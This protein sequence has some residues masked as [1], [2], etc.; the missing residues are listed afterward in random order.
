MR[1]FKTAL[2]VA[3]LLTQ[4]SSFG[5]SN[6]QQEKIYD[7]GI[8]FCNGKPQV[9]ITNI[10]FIK[11]G[12]GLCDTIFS[13]LSPT[14]WPSGIAWDGQ[15]LRHSSQNNPYI[16][17]MDTMGN[18]IDSLVMPENI[19]GL[20]FHDTY[21][22]GVCEESATL[23]KIDVSNN[24]YTTHSLPTMNP[25]DPNTWGITYG[26]ESLWISEYGGSYSA[27]TK[28]YKINPATLNVIDTIFV[29]SNLVLGIIWLNDTIYGLEFGEQK[30]LKINPVNGDVLESE[31]WCIPK[32]YDM[33]IENGYLWNVSGKISHG[34][35]QRVYKIDTGIIL[36]NSILE[37][38]NMEKHLF[39]IYPNPANSE[40]TIEINQES[41]D[42]ELHSEIYNVQ[43]QLFH[44]TKLNNLQTK[45]NINNW[46]SGLYIIMIK[47]GDG[48]L[49]K[50]MIKQ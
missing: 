24:S 45:I 35:T 48:I 21:L 41:T 20:E 10:N 13:F 46:N 26:G 30:K 40:I 18:M 42:S 23:Y 2:F 32:P 27:E 9:E 6:I 15:Y 4:I 44:K 5:Q 22:Y 16:F 36:S 39:T 25:G 11:R 43:G 50:K 37:K 49:I 8:L 47:G 29:N 7:S 33:T 17:K 31:D 38:G 19:S 28:I 3:L 14:D 1:I 34:G 12:R